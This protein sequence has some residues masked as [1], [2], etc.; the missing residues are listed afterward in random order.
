MSRDVA[1]SRCGVARSRDGLISRD[2]TL[3]GITDE[4]NA[5][6]EPHIACNADRLDTDALGVLSSELARIDVR[7]L[8]GEVSWWDGD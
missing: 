3:G 7:S 8:T 1:R 5:R 4:S 6:F 2:E